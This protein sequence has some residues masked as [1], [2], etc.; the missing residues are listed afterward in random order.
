MKYESNWY[1]YINE[2]NNQLNDN[3]NDNNNDN[4]NNEILDII[5]KI[6]NIYEYGILMEYK[7]THIPLYKFFNN[8]E[9]HILNIKDES[10]I[11]IKKAEY[12]I[13]K[14]TILKNIFIKINKLHSIKTKEEPKMSFLNNLKKEIYDKLYNRKNIIDDFINYFGN[15]T[16]VNNIKIDTFENIVEKCKK[17][18]TDYYLNN[19]K[20]N[21]SIILGD[22]QF[23]IILINPDNISDIIFIDPRGYFGNS[24]IYGPVEYDYAKILYGISGYDNFNFNFFNIKRINHKNIEFEIKDF[25]FD[26]EIINKYFSKIH[27]TYLVI[28]WLSLAEYNKNSIWKCMASYYY[29]LYLGTIL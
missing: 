1:K 3:D 25:K 4:N 12:N 17:I 10:E 9:N 15:I 11:N 20:Y 8:Y 29:G 26:E 28:I 6:Y 27:K 13:I 24:M 19:E 23:S 7:K 14:N 16:T 5:P 2:L 18:I 22:C 21:Y